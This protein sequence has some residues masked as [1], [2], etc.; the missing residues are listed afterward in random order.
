MGKT[1]IQWAQNPDG[2]P[3]EVS[4]PVVGCTWKSPGCT[5][6]YARVTHDK[7]F[8][9]WKRGNW[10]DAP[11]Q[12]HKPFKKVQLLPERLEQY[13]KWRKP[14]RVFVN[15]MSDLFHEDV[16]GE[17][18]NQVWQ[19][20]FNT[21]RHTYIILTKRPE[22]LLEWTERKARATGW[23]MREIWPSWM[24]VGASVENQEMAER[25]VSL[26]MQ[27][28]AQVQLL[29][30]EPLLGDVDLSPWLVFDRQHEKAEWS[31]AHY[32]K[33]QPL[34]WLI[35]GGESG[36]RA[37]PMDLT[38]AQS[39]VQQGQAAGVPVFVKQMGQVWARANGAK[40]RHGG[41]MSEWPEALR[42]REWPESEAAS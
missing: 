35:I 13:A 7:R 4:N 20:M 14:R 16:P 10:P 32:G 34:S 22:R 33:S 30:L 23:P 40:E 5:N 3:G 31:L 39:L 28:Q 17:F 19:A 37:R 1:G 6:C 12:Y 29:S 36:K 42:V 25:R 18:I 9:A 27:T 2:T 21:K 8:L 15:S 24:Q 41:E 38:W 26:L 11:A